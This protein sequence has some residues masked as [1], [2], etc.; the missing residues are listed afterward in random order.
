MSRVKPDAHRHRRRIVHQAAKAATLADRFGAPPFTVLDGRQGYWL[1]RKRRWIALG[2]QS[3][4]GRGDAAIFTHVTGQDPTYYKQKRAVEQRLGRTVDHEEFRRRWYSASPSKMNAVSVFDPFLCELVY[5]WYCPAGGEVL[6]PF[7]GGSVRGVVAAKLGLKY[8]G[9]ELRREQVEANRAQARTLVKAAPRPRW[10]V[11]DSRKLTTLTRGKRVDL[12][13]SCPPYADREVYSDDP[14]DLSRM[15]FEGFCR[16]LREIIASSVMLLRPDRFAC[17]VI[18]DVR[19]K[20][21]ALRGLPSIVGRYF[22]E[23]GAKLY[24]H[25]VLVTPTG[26]LPIR[27]PHMFTTSRKLGPAHQHVAT[28]GG[29]PSSSALPA[30]RR[31]FRPRRPASR[32]APRSRFEGSTRGLRGALE[33]H[34]RGARRARGARREPRLIGPQGPARARAKSRFGGQTRVGARAGPV[35]LGPPNIAANPA[36]A[37]VC[38]SAPV[39]AAQSRFAWPARIKAAQLRPLYPMTPTGFEPVLPP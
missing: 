35:L 39:S 3:E 15:D 18:G 19:D 7:A 6:D 37:T 30:P 20:A 29:P 11:G 38:R 4:L 14:R 36:C 10:I 8:V 2:L 13:F 28:P 31:P 24:N 5:R 21:G 34:V 32:R 16:S 33:S 23:G 22:E 26:T 1:Q 25:A 9:V 17:F 12:V 27:A